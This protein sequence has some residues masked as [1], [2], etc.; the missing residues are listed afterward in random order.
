M[1]ATRAHNPYKPRGELCS[2][3]VIQFPGGTDEIHDLGF[4]WLCFHAKAA[5][6]LQSLHGGTRKRVSVRAM[7][8]QPLP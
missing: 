2:P 7:R 1:F 3:V 5:L 4:G 6:R 8:L